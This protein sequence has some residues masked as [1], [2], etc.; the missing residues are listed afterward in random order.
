M[1]VDKQK[2]LQ[3]RLKSSLTRNR[4]KVSTPCLSNIYRRKNK[5]AHRIAHLFV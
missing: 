1:G 4:T 3:H 2:E 5:T